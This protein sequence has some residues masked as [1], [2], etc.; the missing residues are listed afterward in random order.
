MILHSLYKGR[1]LLIKYTY[2][3]HNSNN[4]HNYGIIIRI[5]G[6]P[7]STT[8]PIKKSAYQLLI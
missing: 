7:L 4:T 5:S 2:I 8:E 1:D 6:S 3:I